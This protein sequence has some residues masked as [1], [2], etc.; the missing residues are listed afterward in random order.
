MN[1]CRLCDE[2]GAKKRAVVGKVKVVERVFTSLF[3]LGG[4]FLVMSLLTTA[5]ATS[6][7]SV[8]NALFVLVLVGFL[9]VVYWSH[10]YFM[11]WEE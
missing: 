3:L 10:K 4:N 7:G 9:N 2:R 1:G 5:Y 8:R 6:S 11:A